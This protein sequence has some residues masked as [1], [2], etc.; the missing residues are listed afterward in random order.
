MATLALTTEWGHDTDS[1]PQLAGAF[2]GA[3]HGEKIFSQDA[4][5]AV[6][7]QLLADYSEKLDEW[8][9]VLKQ[10]SELAH[11]TVK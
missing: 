2:I 3:L 9:K 1:Y 11:Q 5:T 7:K 8:L 10:S 4:R 6:E